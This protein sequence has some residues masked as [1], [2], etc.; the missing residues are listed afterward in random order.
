MTHPLSPAE[1]NELVQVIAQA[2]A[3][4]TGEIRV[5]F[6]RHCSGDVLARAKRVFLHLGM[7]KTQNRNAVLIYIALDSRKV[8]IVGDEAIHNLVSQD[9][10]DR[11][12]QTIISHFSQNKFFEGLKKAVTDTGEKL[13]IYFPS[14]GFNQ[15]ELP[16]DITIS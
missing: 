11:E 8:A 9:F 10:W 6:D 3:G 13:K 16:N 12:L 5:H 1:E 4:T 14:E 2:E 15:D 7:E